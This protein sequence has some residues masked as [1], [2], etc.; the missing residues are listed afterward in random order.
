MYTNIMHNINAT[1]YMATHGHSNK[2]TYSF[3]TNAEL[4]HKL[5]IIGWVNLISIY[6]Q[7][8]F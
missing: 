1:R 4:C 3:I 7:L 6:V 5:P 2:F 8:H